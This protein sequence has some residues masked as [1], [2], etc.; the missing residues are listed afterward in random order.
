MTNVSK[1]QLPPPELSVLFLQL[2]TI[3][4]KL[5]QLAA[6]DFLNDLLGEEERIMIA[7]RFAIIIMLT[8][9]YSAYRI[10]QKLRVST[11]TVSAI[12]TKYQHGEYDRLLSQLSHNK[13]AYKNIWETLDSILHLGGILPHYN[14]LDRYK[15]L[16]N[17]SVN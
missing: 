2:N 6:N 15:F 8:E 3:I 7:K 11:A 1:K 17:L 13:Q 12:N 4:G 10:S 5:D 16:K 9:S 14:G